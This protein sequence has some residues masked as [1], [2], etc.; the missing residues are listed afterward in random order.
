[1]D[2][3][4]SIVIVNY[5][6]HSDTV[7]CLESILKISYLNFSVYVVDNSNG[8]ESLA[9]LSSWS[10]GEPLNILTDYPDI[11]FPLVTKPVEVVFIPE[12][13]LSSGKPGNK[14]T[15]IKAIKNQGF[16]AANNIAIKWVMEY[17]Q[18][19]FFWLLNNDTIVDKESLSFLVKNMVEGD[20]SIGILG[21]KLYRYYN[22]G[23]LQGV[24]G[25]YNRWFGK[26]REIGAGELDSGQWDDSSFELDYVIGA[27]MFVKTDFIRTVGLMESDYFLY[28]EELD[29]AIRGRRKKWRQAFCPE[30][31]VYH[32]MGGS[33]NQNKQN[34]NSKLAD[35]YSVRN[36]ILVTRKYF[37]L[38]LITLYPAFSVFVINRLILGQ[39]SRIRMMFRI[40]ANPNEHL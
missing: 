34:G 26:V 38:G 3:H 35:F 36:R 22:R 20:S 13:E 4:V 15:V 2:K 10:K 18:S 23:I 6:G 33:I 7:E 28:Y 30:S 39:F 1:M 29:W 32:K 11:V 37:P 14:I 16:A 21:S 8:T 40:L 27:S 5:N 17:G 9:Y 24:G 31:M 19:D 12:S 25:K